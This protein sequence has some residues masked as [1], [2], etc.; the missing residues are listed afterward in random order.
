MK[1]EKSLAELQVVS[2]N[3]KLA[4]CSASEYC[5]R[6]LVKSEAL[7]NKVMAEQDMRCLNFCFDASPLCRGYATAAIKH[8]LEGGIQA[9]SRE[10]GRSRRGSRAL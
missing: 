7:V 5:A 4:N 2:E 9:G 1:E 10:P 3:S 6:L 8:S